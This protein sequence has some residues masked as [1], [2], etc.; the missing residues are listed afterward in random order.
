MLEKRCKLLPVTLILESALSLYRMNN[1]SLQGGAR[2]PTGGDSPRAAERQLNRCDS[3]TNGIVRMEEDSDPICF[4]RR[5]DDRF[6]GF[7]MFEIRFHLL[8][9]SGQS[10]RKGE[11]I[12]M[13]NQAV[14][15]GSF[16]RS[17]DI[18][19]RYLVAAAMLS[20]VSVVLQYIEI[21]IPIMPAFIKLDLSDLPSLIGSFA[22][23]P[24]WGVAIAGVKNLIHLLVSQSGGVGELANF[25]LNAVFV[26]TAGLIYKRNKTKKGALIGSFAGA[27]AMAILSVPINYF[28]VYP[29]YTAFM[30]MEAIIKAYQVIYPGIQD[31]NLLQCLLI[32]N[33]PFTFVKAM[34]SVVI[35]M[36]VYKRISPLIR[37]TSREG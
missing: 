29:F 23:G 7:C 9:H 36:L 13:T 5:P 27:A 2:F 22:M 37:G 16:I 32:F 17:R 33:L 18:V 3:G 11:V 21:P 6:S 8:N 31:G 14:N 35:V 12:I 28:I 4:A 1:F 19:V 30:P 26:A 15:K 24:L 34:I 10:V 20:A 25:L